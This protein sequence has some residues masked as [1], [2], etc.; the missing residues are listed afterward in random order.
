MTSVSPRLPRTAAG[1]PSASRTSTP[2][3]STPRRSSR[4][5]DLQ[6]D[7]LADL[8]PNRATPPPVPPA[9][10]V[11]PVPAELE[12]A[13]PVLSLHFSPLRWSRPRVVRAERGA[14]AGL[15]FGPIR[16]E[17]AVRD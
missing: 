8:A 7:L 10:A 4:Q 1:T 13:T 11:E 5:A 15:R 17:I 14:G 6:A 2:R 9:P 12:D 16:L 3:T